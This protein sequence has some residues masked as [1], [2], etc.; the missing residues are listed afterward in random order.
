M[1]IE[2]ITVLK[3]ADATAIYGSR[4]ANGALLITT[5]KGKAGKTKTDVN[6]QQGW[7]HITRMADMMNT[8]QYLDMRYEAYNNDNINW[9]D[10]SVSANDLKFWDTT[11]YTNWQKAFIGNVSLYTNLSASISGGNQTV[12]YLLGTTYHRETSVFPGSMTDQKGSL[13]FSL[14]TVS[15]NQRF[16]IQFSGTYEADVNHLPSVDLTT[17]ALWREPD[18]PNP[19]NKDG[20]LNW[21]PDASGTS[22]TNNPLQ[23]LQQSYN[24][25]SKN[26]LTNLLLS[27]EILPGLEL[28]SNFGYTSLQQD[29][30][31][32]IPLT[33]IKPELQSITPRSA[34]Y[35]YKT[36][37]DWIVEPQLTYF[38]KW[39]GLNI[40]AL[41]GT[42]FQ[43]NDNN[44][45]F[46]VGTGYSSD[47]Q[48]N[49]I[50]SASSVSTYGTSDVKYKYTAVF[51]RLNLNW[52]NKYLL[53][54]TAR[55]D[56]SSNFGVSNRFHGFGSVGAG[57]I[58][59]EE[60]F[61]RHGNTF[62][63]FGKLRS[64]YGTT[65][66][67]QIGAYSNVNIYGVTYAGI[68]YQNTVGLN[69]GDLYNPYLQWELTKKWQSGID[70]GFMHDR[71]LLSVTYAR[72]RSSNELL[73]SSVPAITGFYSVLNN[74]P[75]TVQN[76]SWEFSL[77]TVNI[78]S[79]NFSWKS[80]FNLTIPRNEVIAF[81]QIA[82]SF[83]ADSSEGV[84]IGQPLGV[85]KIF[86]YLG[87]DPA[88]GQY[89][90]ADQ[91]GNPTT[92]P[93]YLTDRTALVSTLPRYYGGLLNSF[94]YKGFA[95]DIFFQF[96]RQMGT[97][98][99][100][101]FAT[102]DPGTFFRGYSN[103]PVSVLNRWQKPGDVKSVAAFTTTG[104]MV[105]WPQPFYSDGGYSMDASYIRL[106]NVSLS[107]TLP[108]SW[109][110]SA[111][112]QNGRIYFQG[113]NLLTITKY[114]GLDPENQSQSALPPL[115]VFTFGIQLGF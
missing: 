88:T 86:H 2:S 13:H 35:T 87:V 29:L 15:V 38:R 26:L 89:Q 69:P 109:L 90:V 4:A 12:Q 58:F 27:Y 56:G 63:S 94:N 19:Y 1:D 40:D 20:S 96:V 112:L 7:G 31:Q 33:S 114:S 105:V 45:L 47:L 76:T 53:N 17:Y 22:T 75:A 24:S 62:L 108:A 102:E 77:S 70:L 115:R 39:G 98:D 32:P 74:L 59:S 81:P 93:N 60:N 65:G 10:P 43:Q 28:K 84:I 97:K 49:N 57:W 55:R 100:Y 41:L 48:L 64:S 23:Y 82:N 21:A 83:Y 110:N 73:P 68:P 37:G 92:N 103:Q 18:A 50:I 14:N 34:A 80:T 5:K 44:T 95:L 107:W 52:Y 8:R 99:L 72:N 79:K 54:F 25:T 51:G 61:I 111:H 71:L 9:R 78:K 42:T 11:S 85:Q 113:Q 66:N 106:K 91:K 3:D 101:Y 67:D 46:L 30:Y 16:K 6:L 36:V 104:T